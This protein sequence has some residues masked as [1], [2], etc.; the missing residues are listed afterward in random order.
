MRIGNILTHGNFEAPIM[1][2]TDVPSH[3]SFK[4]G[5][6][7]PPAF[8]KVFAYFGSRNKFRPT[9][10]CY[11]SPCAPFPPGMGDSKTLQ[12]EWLKQYREEFLS[13]CSNWT[14][15]AI[16]P[17]GAHAAQQLMGKP[18][19]ITRVRGVVTPLPEFDN[20]PMI[21][22]MSPGQVLRQPRLELN[23]RAD[24]EMIRQLRDADFDP[25][26]LKF[27]VGQNYRWVNA[28]AFNAYVKDAIRNRPDPSA[29]L[30]VSMDTETIGGK[31]YEGA[32]PIMGQVSFKMGEGVAIPLSV[33]LC[34]RILAS[35]MQSSKFR[36]VEDDD[37][38]LIRERV[39]VIE[40]D[41]DEAFKVTNLIVND[42]ALWQLA[43]KRAEAIVPANYKAFKRLMQGEVHPVIFTGQ[44]FKYDIHVCKNADIEID[45]D[46]W[47]HDTM[48]LSFV[49]DENIQSKDLASLTRIWIPPLAGY[50]DEF[51]QT[52]NYAHM[53]EVEHEKIMHYGVADT[54]T[55]FRL[56]RRLV[57][58][59]MQDQRHYNCYERI[60][61]PAL[62]M[63]VDVER[64]GIQIDVPALRAFS[65][66][67]V[68]AEEEK[69]QEL[70]EAVDG[71]IKQEFFQPKNKNRYGLS[72]T[73]DALVIAQLFEHPK[74]LKLEPKMLTPTGLPSVSTKNHLPYFE[75]E[76]WVANFIE[77]EKMQKLLTT[78]IGVE[79]HTEVK[80]K[81][82]GEEY[83]I[84]VGAT[85]IW[86]YIASDGCIRPSYML[87]RT[88]TGRT[89]SNDPNGQNFPKRGDL[90]MEYRKIFIPHEGY[91]F[92]E[93]DLSQAELRIAAWMANE[94]NMIRLYKEGEDIHAATG[95]A[96]AGIDLAKFKK[97]QKDDRM[98]L[99][100][101]N[102]W[103]GS[104]AYLQRLNPGS[105]SNPKYGSVK[106]YM[107]NL[108]QQAKAVNFG[109][110]YG[111]GWKK[112]MA[113][114]KTT[115]QVE[116]TETEAKKMRETF[117]KLYPGLV[118]WHGEM[119]EFVRANAFVRSVHG[120]K[121]HL[122]DIYSVDEMIRGSTERQAINSPVQRFASDLALMGAIRLHRDLRR[123]GGD[124]CFITAFIH[125]AVIVEVRKGKEK[126]FAQYLK[127][128][129]ESCPL[130]AWFNIKPPLPLLADVSCCEKNLGDVDEWHDTIPKQ[131]AWFTED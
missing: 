52:V 68:K 110:L 124:D 40:Y 118:R 31:W 1:V 54:D 63:F 21:A 67:M 65:K 61:M 71:E 24:Y 43:L 113:Y 47:E 15:K 128:Y 117:F 107:K 103:P 130:Q 126:E 39:P 99:D 16:V 86:Q 4:A 120:A 51:E 41:P 62:R 98:L 79:A 106:A 87:H 80:K 102:E 127:W 57:P 73:R 22:L 46:A 121:R 94:K 49:M 14:G 91:S 56:T 59:A 5:E 64:R 78:Y 9:D 114:A 72:F 45:I 27:D 89:A 93:V 74:G 19:K 35:E 108:R 97:G 42:P 85:G 36:T 37:G 25:S 131:P 6:P 83:E 26:G 20:K 10:F 90:A 82:N 77:W 96:I 2:V 53:D 101:A 18:V 69:Y 123:R 84:N 3:A 75:E 111:M 48:Q 81:R 119:R 34:A 70:I 33:N 17:F 28:M 7:L 122:Q 112:F 30:A 55:T 32:I 60:Q 88:V 95:A 125:D 66:V 104:G 11:V 109:F 92:L 50:S 100:C 116:V 129:M 76:M 8:H 12:T 23:F 29:P 44:N 38:R 58:D 105:R 13:M 115:Y